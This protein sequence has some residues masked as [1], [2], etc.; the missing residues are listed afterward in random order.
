ML[1]VDVPHA[2]VAVTDKVPLVVGLKVTEFVV[3]E[4][5]PPPEY[6]QE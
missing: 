5:V 3:L 1:E 4:G 6:D 2:F